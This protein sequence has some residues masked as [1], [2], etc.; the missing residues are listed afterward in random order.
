MAF[1]LRFTG[2]D[3]VLSST[4]W[5]DEER[6]RQGGAEAGSYRGDNHKIAGA[7]RLGSQRR[8]RK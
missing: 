5:R 1:V 8:E 3:G 6:K 7:G 2:N 4:G